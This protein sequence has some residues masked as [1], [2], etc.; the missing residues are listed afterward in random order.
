M[1]VT[2]VGQNRPQVAQFEATDKAA[3]KSGGGGAVATATAT[4]TAKATVGAENAVQAQDKA[5]QAQLARDAFEPA[6]V[7][8]PHFAQDFFEP[9]AFEPTAFQPPVFEPAAFEPA[10]FDPAVALNEQPALEQPSF[11]DALNSLVAALNQVVD[12]VQTALPPE[13]NQA[14]DQAQGQTPQGQNPLDALGGGANP[15]N[16]NPLGLEGPGA[17]GTGPGAFGVPAINQNDPNAD[18]ENGDYKFGQT[19]C[20]PTALAQIARGKSLEDPNFSLNYVDENG[21]QQSKRV[22]DM[23]N[24]ELVSTLGKIAGT[25]N[26]GTSPNGLIDAAAKL[27]MDVTDAEVKYDPA[28]KKGQGPS[29]SFD[30]GWLD[31]KLAKGEKVIMNGAYEGKDEKGKDALIGHFVTI[32]GKNDDGTYAVV[33]P[34]DG[35]AKN[36][37]P[38]QLKKFMESNEANGGVM[39]AIGDT[40]EEKAA[41]ANG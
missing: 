25:D 26:L 20:A 3:Q 35:K 6:V 32:A 33:D 11:A 10:A 7:D 4:A 9:A 28:W 36:L 21:V 16:R 24:E 1:A 22:A 5:V 17:F 39:L 38:G 13:V 31:D 34:W 12:L 18:G 2:P 19:N 15:L 30:Q 29:N 40:P 23:T 27:G 8:Q 14:I 41:K 37:T